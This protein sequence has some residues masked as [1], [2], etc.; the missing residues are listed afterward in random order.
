MEKLMTTKEGKCHPFLFDLRNRINL[1]PTAVSD[2]E[3]LYSFSAD[4]DSAWQEIWG[5]TQEV[6]AF[7]VAITSET[8]TCRTLYNMIFRDS[9]GRYKVQSRRVTRETV[10]SLE[11]EQQGHRILRIF[12]PTSPET[13][14]KSSFVD[15][16]E[17]QVSSYMGL[18]WGENVFDLNILQIGGRLSFAGQVAHLLAD[19]AVY[20]LLQELDCTNPA[21]KAENPFPVAAYPLLRLFPKGRLFVGNIIR[22]LP[23]GLSIHEE[24][25]VKVLIAKIFGTDGVRKDMVKAVLTTPNFNSILLAGQLKELYPI[26]W[27]RDL[28][29]SPDERHIF[30]PSA[31]YSVE[32][33]A[34]LVSL[35]ESLTLPQ[36]KRL[37]L[38]KNSSGRHNEWLE[39]DVLGMFSQLN[40]DQK[41][42][43]RSEIDYSSWE[44]LHDSLTKVSNKIRKLEELAD[45][46][47]PINLE[48][49]YME[50][51]DGVTYTLEGETYTLQAPKYRHE[52]DNWGEELNNCIGSYYRY[53]MKSVTNVFGVY[54][55]DG[56]LF[57]NIEITLHGRLSQYMTQGNAEA[58]E[59]HW[60]CVRTLLAVAVPRDSEK[61]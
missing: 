45:G 39:Y 30:N 17:S 15:V 8:V 13:E 32:R 6:M 18:H 52:L 51:L 5:D 19:W 57:G 44:K 50:K 61:P 16:T 47:T 3:L 10:L 43:Y 14:L 20:Q 23:K 53:L 48:R 21:L 22:A 11:N 60:E 25:D 40:V 46:P 24:V 41:E 4:L 1:S 42:H 36:R 35:L 37:L 7:E 2:K 12:K 27:L 56:T 34:K 49:T 28:I 26:E 58:P 55:A 38:D 31:T 9:S 59:E 33:T 54:S 29:A